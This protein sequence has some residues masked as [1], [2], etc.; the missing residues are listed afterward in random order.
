M[1]ISAISS[2]DYLYQY[3]YQLY[4]TK[5]DS[6][7]SSQSNDTATTAVSSTS[8]SNSLA[9]GFSALEDALKAGDLSSAQSSFLQILQ[10][11]SATASDSSTTA[12]SSSTSTDS[13]PLAN[14]LSA[15][16]K[17]LQSGDLSSAQ[18]IF[19][20]IMQNM[21][22]P[23]PD[24]TASDSTQSTTATSSSTGSGTN[25][26]ADDLTALGKAL[27]SGDLTSAQS[28]LSQLQQD[29]QSVSASASSASK[30]GTSSSTGTDLEK[31]LEM[32]AAIAT[33]NTS[34]LDVSA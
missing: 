20:Q 22:P 3:L 7:T 8:S 26:I 2:N 23:P 17:A 29:L 11:I 18:S 16:E 19:A 28:Y 4:S 12:T 6:S 15:L 32:W 21:P 9:N 10:T 24:A 33:E 25:T 31:L 5:T 34:T 14:D 13:N 1:S 27:A 30:T